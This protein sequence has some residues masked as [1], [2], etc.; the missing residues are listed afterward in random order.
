MHNQEYYP[1]IHADINSSTIKT[2]LESWYENNIKNTG[3]SAYVSDEIFCNDRSIDRTIRPDDLGY[4]QNYT[5]YAP[6]TR[7]STNK[8]PSLLCPQKNDAFT[9]ADTINGNG[10]LTYPVGLLTADEIILAGGQSSVNSDYYLYTG[11]YYW[12]LSPYFFTDVD[13]YEFYVNTG[14]SLLN[15]Y[16]NGTFGLRPVISLVAGTT[17]ADN[18]ADG[19]ALKPYVVE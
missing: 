9:K 8:N 7:T 13:A 17:F 18:G 15:L 10:K 11:Q 6:Y 5:L 4:G 12:A 16:V 1:Y 19:T 2:Y 3:Y 14:G